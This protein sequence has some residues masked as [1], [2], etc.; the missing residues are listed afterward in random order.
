MLEDAALNSR[1]PNV[2]PAIVEPIPVMLIFPDPVLMCVP[3]PDILP[4]NKIT[5]PPSD[6][7]PTLSAM[8]AVTVHP[9]PDS[10][11][12]A[13]LFTVRLLKVV[14]E[15]PPIVCALVPL[16]VTVD[17]DVKAAALTLL[18]KFPPKFTPLLPVAQLPEDNITL[19]VTLHAALCVIVF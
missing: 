4:C 16:K 11:T 15:L 3:V 13:A 9:I 5:L 12:P 1:L 7:E 6:K 8:F 18:V 2:S 17:D 19:P 14:A 10:E